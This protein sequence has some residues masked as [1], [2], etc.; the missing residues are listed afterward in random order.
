MDAES[1]KRLLLGMAAAGELGAQ[2]GQEIFD[3]IQKMSNSQLR[4]RDKL[5]ITGSPSSPQWTFQTDEARLNFEQG[6]AA[7]GIEFGDNIGEF[8][9]RAKLPEGWTKVRTDH[10]LYTNLLDHNGRLRAKIMH[11]ARMWDE[12][13]WVGLRRRYSVEQR[14]HHDG[15]PKTSAPN[16]DIIQ[17]EVQD[18]GESVHK[19][20]IVH[21]G[22]C[23]DWDDSTDAR[24]AHYEKND[25]TRKAL[26]KECVDWLDTK[27][28]D[29]DKFS[30][31]WEN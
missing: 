26:E 8:F 7:T 29:W 31:Y 27:Y 28:P 24:S 15:D 22:P 25:E 6:W 17:F 4:N 1:Q 12:A 9:R 30:A 13:A 19:T 21:L 16:F 14:F 20:R 2:A 18:C 10:H 3:A 11:D 5:P 23:P